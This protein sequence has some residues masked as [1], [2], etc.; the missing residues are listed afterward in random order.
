[1]SSEHKEKMEKKQVEQELGQL[2]ELTLGWEDELN[3]MPAY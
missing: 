2:L 3:S 1:M